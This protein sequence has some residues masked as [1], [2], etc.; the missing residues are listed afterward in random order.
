MSRSR[1][2]VVLAGLLVA[3]AASTGF[4]Q[5]PFGTKAIAELPT[6]LDLTSLEQLALQN[7]P[8]L[9]Q[10]GAQITVSRGKALQAGLYP[11]PILGYQA[12]LIGVNG[13]PGEFQ[14]GFVQQTIVTAGKLRLSRAKYSQ[15]AREAAILALG[16]QLRVV[17]GVRTQFYE[18]LAAKRMI[19]LRRDLVNNADENLRTTRE[20]FNTGLANEAQVLLAENEV[21]RAKIG[22]AAQENQYSAFWQHLVAL[23]GSPDLTPRPLD[24]QLE[25]V[26]AP[27]EWDD[28]LNRLLADSPELEAARAHVVHDQIAIHRERVEPIPNITIGAGVGHNFENPGTN[29]NVQA[30]IEVPLFDR[31][32]GTL[33]QAQGDLVRSQ[34][35]VQRVE[36]SLRR[37]LADYFNQYRTALL[38]TEQYRDAMVPNA[39][40][41]YELQLAMYKQR[42]VAWPEVVDLQRN[43]FQVQSDYT[44]SLVELRRAE[45]A[46]TGLLMVDGLSPPTSPTPGDHLEAT[47]T[48]R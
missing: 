46:I 48:P 28:S 38:T 42:R 43:L 2:I 34:A 25:L 12:E 23:L 16:Q 18:L 24:G 13:T 17:N 20:M 15:E 21:N 35:A 27:L 39:S 3:V 14:G 36:L 8:T 40:K 44:Q 9:V 5:S 30:A 7:N 31:N 41:A 22:L 47:P 37:Q 6:A 10:A 19:V 11:N 1:T 4:G 45:V 29:T 26:G 32:Q 33:R